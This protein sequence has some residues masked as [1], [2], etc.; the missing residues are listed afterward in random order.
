MN[1]YPIIKTRYRYKS[2]NRSLVRVS[3]I[4][5]GFCVIVHI[6]LCF[7]WYDIYE[8]GPN[9]QVR[10]VLLETIETLSKTLS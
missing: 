6:L 5:I 7:V 8:N 10:K 1:T 4:T 9:N 3:I 2:K